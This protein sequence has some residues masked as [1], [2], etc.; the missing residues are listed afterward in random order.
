MGCRCIGHYLAVQYVFVLFVGYFCYN[1]LH[2]TAKEAG[3]R[4]NECPGLLVVRN[5][6]FRPYSMHN[7]NQCHYTRNLLTYVL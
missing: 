3:R 6:D 5:L 7:V 4:L 1:A 2:P